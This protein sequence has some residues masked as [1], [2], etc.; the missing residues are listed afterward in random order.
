MRPKSAVSRQ[1]PGSP[2]NKGGSRQ[3]GLYKVTSA[4]TFGRENP[5]VT[6]QAVTRQY[7]GGVPPAS[8][9]AFWGGVT[10]ARVEPQGGEAH[11]FGVGSSEHGEAGG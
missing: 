10:D 8:F 4:A 6:R 5:A 2:K 7:R 3:S 11:S 9:D 1:R